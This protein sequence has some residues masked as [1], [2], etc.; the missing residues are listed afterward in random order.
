MGDKSKA[1]QTYIN[2]IKALVYP[3]CIMD[4]VMIGSKHKSKPEGYL[5]MSLYTYF[6][7]SMSIDKTGAR[8]P[9]KQ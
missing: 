4:H 9:P 6:A 2:Q 5:Q 7:F 1:A 3:K 8:A